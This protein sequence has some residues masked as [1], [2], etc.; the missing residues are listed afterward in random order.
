MRKL[1]LCCFALVFILA[2]SQSTP[3]EEGPISSEN[4]QPE[5]PIL[6]ADTFLKQLS[7]ADEEMIFINF[8]ATWCVPCREEFP[9]L[10]K[11]EEEYRGKGL[12]FWAVSCDTAEEI[13]TSV[14]QF[15]KEMDSGLT[16]FAIDLE[17]RDKIIKMVSPDWHGPIPATF[18]L[19]RSGERFFQQIG[20]MTHEQ[21][22]ASVQAAL[23][24]IAEGPGDQ[25]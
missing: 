23:D 12:A 10:V 3:P 22:K 11:V 1:G 13:E 9:D 2:C 5:I 18:I 21:F 7:A 8:W 6:T 17:E 15:L 24:A 14:P 19:R 4:S 20:P 16:P 25:R